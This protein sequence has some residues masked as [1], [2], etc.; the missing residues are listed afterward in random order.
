MNGLEYQGLDLSYPYVYNS[1]CSSYTTSLES[2]N[3]PK[4]KKENPYAQ[5]LV[6]HNTL[7]QYL[8]ILS[9]ILNVAPGLSLLHNLV[10]FIPYSPQVLLASS[11]YLSYLELKSYLRITW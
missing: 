9:L 4:Y 1:L 5:F 11:E 3:V 6:N 10:R 7:Q 8:W 2:N